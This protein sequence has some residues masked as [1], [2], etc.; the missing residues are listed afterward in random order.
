MSA[1]FADPVHDAQRAFRAALD[2]LSRPGRPVDVGHDIEGLPLGAAMAH[3]L[4][5]LTDDDTAVWWQNSAGVALPWLRFHTGAKPADAPQEAAFAA[6]VAPLSMP[7]LDAF[8]HGTLASPEFSTTLVIEVDSLDAGPSLQWHGP[9]IRDTQAVRV[10]GLPNGFWAQWQANHASFPQGVDV[11]FTC[12][13]KAIGLPRTT[14][15]S[16]VE[17]I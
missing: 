3:L 11:I 4:L 2:A 8:A 14:R 10:G 16:R 17:G 5:A 13:A 6:I 9:G 7:A 1:G 15:V 12:G